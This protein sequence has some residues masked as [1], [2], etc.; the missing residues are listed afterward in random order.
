[1]WQG[2]VER[3]SVSSSRKL[4]KVNT[5]LERR[6]CISQTEV[7]EVL[8]AEDGLLDG[9]LPVNTQLL[10]HKLNASIGFGMIEVVAL[11]LEDGNIAEHR[12]AMGKTTGNEE[13]AV[14]VLAKL[15][16]NMLT[17][18]GRSLTDVDSDIKYL[19]LDATHNLALR[20][21][22]TLVVETT[23]DTIGGH[24]FVVLYELD[25]THLGV[26]LALRER[27]EEIA[28]GILEHTGLYDDDA[29]KGGR[30]YFHVLLLSQQAAD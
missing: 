6:T 15:Y 28:T 13:L 8:V 12:K 18:G 14:V 22:R 19:A 9:Y 24:A 11:V 7:L 17:I 4:I 29:L 2:T 10:I 27:L 23:N 21:G 25:G 5:I 20:I 26:E 30:D 3:T 16:G 1:M